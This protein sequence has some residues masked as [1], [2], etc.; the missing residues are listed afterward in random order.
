MVASNSEL[1]MGLNAFVLQLLQKNTAAQINFF[2]FFRQGVPSAK[3]VVKQWIVIACSWRTH[4]L[5]HL[6]VLCPS[7]HT[8][9][10]CVIVEVKV[11][12]CW[13]LLL[14]CVPSWRT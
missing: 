9:I 5:V 12:I 3:L 1:V 4:L 8:I 10:Y 13:V 11:S 2:L 7:A 6:L 14:T